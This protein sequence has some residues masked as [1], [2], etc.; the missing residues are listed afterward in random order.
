MPGERERESDIKQYEVKKKNSSILFLVLRQHWVP[1]RGGF[2]RGGRGRDRIGR[3]EWDPTR[4]MIE[5]DVPRC[6]K[7]EV[8][9]HFRFNNIGRYDRSRRKERVR[10]SHHRWALLSR[11]ELRP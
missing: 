3:N 1:E 7:P 5:A 11:E 8:L 6:S 10:S 4:T 2:E 9:F